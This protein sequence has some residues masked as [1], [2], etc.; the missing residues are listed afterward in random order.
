[1]GDYTLDNIKAGWAEFV[2]VGCS[3]LKPSTVD[4][5]RAMLT[6]GLN[7]GADP[8]GYD[9]PKIKPIKF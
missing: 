4:R 2:K 9:A 5:F 7:H 6:A 8:L 1:M 3:G